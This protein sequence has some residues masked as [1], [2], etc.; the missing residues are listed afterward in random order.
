MTAGLERCV[1]CNLSRVPLT[2]TS[3]MPDAKVLPSQEIPGKGGVVTLANG[4]QDLPRVTNRHRRQLN[5]GA[6]ED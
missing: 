5:V 1:G 2:L 3:R 6:A 4:L